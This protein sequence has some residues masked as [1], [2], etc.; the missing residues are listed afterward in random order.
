MRFR[1]DPKLARHTEVGRLR[2]YLL[3][4]SY[5]RL[6]MSLLVALTAGA[7]L[8]AS[9]VLL[10]AGMGSMGLRYPL[11]VLIAYGVFLGLLW[12][13]MR[14]AL[15]DHI[16]DAVDVVDRWQARSRSA[17]SEDHQPSRTSF[18][19]ATDR[20]ASGDGVSF[21]DA[22]EVIGSADEA[23]IPLALIAA[24]VALLAA[25]TFSLV[26]VVWAAPA[27]FAELLFDGVLAVGL[28]RRLRRADVRHWLQSALRHTFWP[29]MVALILAA[30]GGA[31]L[32]WHAPQATTV[33]QALGGV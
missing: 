17:S 26:S 10:H 23:A 30:A 25:L 4:R 16:E 12:L 9:F 1:P 29:F 28:Y 32:Q 6:Q 2:R 15:A 31:L 20:S 22:F 8:A 19:H 33:S 3:L 7:G 13:W 5:P 21:G 14:S 24:L 27:L 18:D 11:A